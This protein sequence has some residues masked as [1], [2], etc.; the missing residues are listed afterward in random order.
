MAQR[1]LYVYFGTLI[2]RPSGL[3]A[4]ARFKMADWRMDDVQLFGSKCF[5]NYRLQNPGMC[6]YITYVIYE[7]LTRVCTNI[8][9]ESCAID[10]M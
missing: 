7:Y 1:L 6:K 2:E 8:A 3:H 9:R 10:D 5:G 4:L